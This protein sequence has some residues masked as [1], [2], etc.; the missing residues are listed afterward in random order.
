M[1]HTKSEN[2]FVQRY[3]ITERLYRHR[4]LFSLN[5]ITEIYF[6]VQKKHFSWTGN[7]LATILQVYWLN[8][9]DSGTLDCRHNLIISKIK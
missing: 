1:S 2:F 4:R 6:T 9:S 5:I 8:Y 3:F 7:T